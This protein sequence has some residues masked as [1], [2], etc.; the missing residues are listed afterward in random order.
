MTSRDLPTD[1]HTGEQPAGGATEELAIP[2]GQLQQSPDQRAL[3]TFSEQTNE[4]HQKFLMDAVNGAAEINSFIS[5][6]VHMSSEQVALLRNAA[7]AF[8]QTKASIEPGRGLNDQAA[9]VV[10]DQARKVFNVMKQV[11][12]HGSALK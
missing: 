10:G 8:S 2:E 4:G 6:H 12:D 9:V 1:V 3:A 7:K 5:R 11:V